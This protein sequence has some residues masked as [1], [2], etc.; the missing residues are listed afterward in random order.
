MRNAV[1]YPNRSGLY[2]YKLRS[3]RTYRMG[4]LSVYQSPYSDKILRCNPDNV[5][6][7]NKTQGFI[8]TAFLSADEVDFNKNKNRGYICNINSISAFKNLDGTGYGTVYGNNGDAYKGAFFTVGEQ[9]LYVYACALKPNPDDDYE[10]I[11]TSIGS[12]ISEID[13]D[14]WLMDGLTPT[15]YTVST[16]SHSIY[17]SRYKKSYS[18]FDR[19][20]KDD[21][22]IDNTNNVSIEQSDKIREVLGTKK[23]PLRA[24]IIGDSITYAA[25]NAGL[26]NA[27]RKYISTKMGMYEPT[28]MAVSGTGIIDGAP[29][30]FLSNAKTSEDYRLDCAGVTG[31]MN[32]I[33]ANL[34]GDTTTWVHSG[35]TKVQARA[36]LKAEFDVAIV[37]L[38]TNDF[39]NNGTLGSISTIDDT[40]TFYGAVYTFYNFLM[41]NLNVRNV[42]F[43][44]PFPRKDI[45]MVTKNN[46]S[47]PYCL[48][49]MAH[50]LAEIAVIHPN[51]HVLDLTGAWYFNTANEEIAKKAFIDGVHITGWAHHLVTMDMAREIERILAYEDTGWRN[52]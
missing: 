34:E 43:V 27:W 6:N 35:V 14:V 47:T 21:V 9:D 40:S 15:D 20:N 39:T 33:N 52:S 2:V 5:A 45:N 13:K 28:V 7:I 29:Y 37:A 25:S 44:A 36:Y 8:S 11:E 42:L 1:T 30:D 3:G 31:L 12:V 19:E 50:A 49:E 32:W 16:G 22:F 18:G 4:A 10:I 24:M 46:A 17:R 48:F 26:Q 41:E 23:K 51:M 38:G